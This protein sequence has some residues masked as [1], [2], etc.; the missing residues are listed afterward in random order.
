M[1][2]ATKNMV[3]AKLR[4]GLSPRTVAEMYGLS[5]KAVE[6]FRDLIKQL[7]HITV[8]A[9]TPHEIAVRDAALPPLSVGPADLIELAPATVI[10]PNQA[11]KIVAQHLKGRKHQEIAESLNL[12]PNAVLAKIRSYGQKMR[13]SK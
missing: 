9:L 2:E 5:V 12:D 13:R 11:S 4:Q 3:L 7:S 1:T 8:R 10:T 6:E